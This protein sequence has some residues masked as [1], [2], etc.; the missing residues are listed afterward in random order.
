MIFLLTTSFAS[1][2]VDDVLH[3]QLSEYDLVVMRKEVN[4]SMFYDISLHNPSFIQND[5][6]YVDQVTFLEQLLHM[7]ILLHY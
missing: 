2:M 6:M 7:N 1:K 4:Q 3:F 5:D